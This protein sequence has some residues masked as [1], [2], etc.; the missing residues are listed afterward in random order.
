MFFFQVHPFHFQ[1]LKGQLY[2]V[3]FLEA[4]DNRHP[5]LLGQTPVLSKEFHDTPDAER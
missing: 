3:D 5:K 4:A 2:I 1:H